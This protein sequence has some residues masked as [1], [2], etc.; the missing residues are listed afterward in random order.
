[1]WE[2]VAGGIWRKDENSTVG[3]YV[4]GKMWVVFRESARS[5]VRRSTHSVPLAVLGPSCCLGYSYHPHPH[6]LP[7][8]A[9]LGACRSHSVS[10]NHWG[11]LGEG[12]EVFVVVRGPLPNCGCR[13]P[14]PRESGQ[15][16]Q[17]QGSA[18]QV[19]SG[20]F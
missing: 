18:R 20:L 13:L 11:R 9:V 15:Y 2:S 6:S 17:D 8:P 10:P 16:L 1:M 3:F 7:C 5:G 12:A 4:V 14:Q 19:A